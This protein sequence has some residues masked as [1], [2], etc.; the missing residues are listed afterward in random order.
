VPGKT[1]L[2]DYANSGLSI[3]AI[4]GAQR[5]NENGARK[6]HGNAPK[7]KSELMKV[8]ICLAYEIH[9]NQFT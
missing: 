2:P 5:N 9:K 3:P 4:G 7:L 6:N 8:S 1:E